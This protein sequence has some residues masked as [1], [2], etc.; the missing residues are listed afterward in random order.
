MAG[1]RFEKGHTFERKKKQRSD[2]RAQ[3]SSAPAQSE[4]SGS[5]HASGERVRKVA[6]SGGIH[7]EEGRVAGSGDRDLVTICRTKSQ[8]MRGRES[9]RGKGPAKVTAGRGRGRM[10]STE[11]RG[12]GVAQDSSSESEDN[13]EEQADEV[14]GPLKLHRPRR[15][16]SVVDAPKRTVNYMKNVSRVVS[17]RLNNPYD[18]EKNVA[19]YRFWNDFQAD[20]YETVILA[21][22]KPI[23]PM[24]WIDWDYMARKNDP[25]FTEVIAACES[26]RV[27][28]IMA[29]R[30]DWCEEVIAQFYATVWFEGCENPIMHWMTEGVKYRIS[31]RGF[32]HYF[33]LDAR[34]TSKDQIH[35]ENQLTLE[36]IGFMYLN[37]GRV[38]F[39]KLTGMRPFYRCLNS[40]F[41]L[42]LA[43][44]SGD[45]TTV[46]SI[47]RNLL[48][49]MSNDH[50]PFSVAHFLWEEIVFT[51]K[52][53]I[54]SCGYAPYLMFIIERISKKTFVKEI[55]HEPY[56]MRPLNIQAPS[57][58]PSPPHAPPSSRPFASRRAPPRGSSFIK[59]ALKAIFKICTHNATQ[60]KD[61]GARLKKMENRQKQ[62]YTSMNLQP[63]CSPIESD[64]A[65]SA[66]FEVE[67]PWAWYDEAQ[68][69]AES[70][71]QQA[72][73]D[74]SDGNE[75]SEDEEEDDEEDGSSE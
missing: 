68:A 70:S 58:S 62:M 9:A 47:S 75:G 26:K 37:H 11:E 61:Q 60:I 52:S 66:P 29:F 50:A 69:A 16:A 2:P 13:E 48:A 38:E 25:V 21:K 55:K 46:Q 71:Q 59:S 14:I 22:K 41:R 63:P 6:A 44:K 74:S 53:P 72:Q 28:N 34:D 67:N 57:P 15:T 65:E 18:F 35:N 24:Q 19:D 7:I 73:D 8:A 1:D 17:E 23:T 42:T 31:F 54:K 30:Y 36:E 32:A 33:H 56:R 40:L 49:A 27:K 39:G 45:A 5:G 3:E 20:F 4:D 10:P 51:S 43:P 12:K 64:E